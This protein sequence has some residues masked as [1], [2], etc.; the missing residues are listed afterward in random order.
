MRRPPRTCWA[1][2]RQLVQSTESASE[3]LTRQLNDWVSFLVLPLFALANAGVTFSGGIVRELLTSR[4]A[5]GVLLGLVVGKPL[6]ILGFSKLAVRWRL[7][8]LPNG[9]NLA[10]DRRGWHA[11][12]H[13]LHGLDLHQLVGL[14]QRLV[15]GGGKNG[16]ACSFCHLR[17][18]WATSRCGSGKR[19]SNQ[20]RLR[21]LTTPT[22]ARPKT[23]ETRYNSLVSW[24]AET[25][26]S[27][28]HSSCT[29]FL[30]VPLF[31][32]AGLVVL[33]AVVA[34]RILVRRH[35]ERKIKVMRSRISALVLSA[36]LALSL[37]ACSKKEQSQ[38]PP[39]ATDTSSQAQA[40]QPA[41]RSDGAGS[42]RPAD[43]ARHR[44][45]KWRRRLLSRWR[46][47]RT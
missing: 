46:R 2:S 43:G 8:Q 29:N 39:A 40:N 14:R 37:A 13:R 1:L 36:I 3:R 9:V 27:A 11:G 22:E 35:N 15:S 28:A 6:G 19:F 25:R 4:V 42:S 5:W 32:R 16:R 20:R 33:V 45:S 12:G 31:G 34:G 7:A 17:A 10:A 18:C 24:M 47:L 30:C 23:G 44:I 21:L 26:L 38:N 41:W